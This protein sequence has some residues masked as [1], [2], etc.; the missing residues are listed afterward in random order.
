MRTPSWN[1][2]FHAAKERAKAKA[3]KT[4]ETCH[5]FRGAAGFLIY[6]DREAEEMEFDPSAALAVFS[7]E[8]RR[9]YL[10]IRT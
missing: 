4:G 1:A 2:K 9:Y 5:V 6:T 10:I 7:P 8:G 3:A